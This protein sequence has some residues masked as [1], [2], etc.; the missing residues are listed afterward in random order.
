[1][2]GL[3]LV[4]GSAKRIGRAIALDLA[5]HGWDIVVHYNRS[6]EEAKTLAE[7]IQAL[8]QMAYLAEIDLSNTD[9][10]EKLIPFLTENLGPLDA[11][12]NNAALFE[13]DAT[14]PDGTRHWAVNAD[15]PRLLSKSLR[16]SLNKGDKSVVVN[17]LD[18]T[19]TAPT[20]LAY[21]KSKD[22][23]KTLTVNMA[24]SFAPQVRVNGVAPMYVLPSPRQTEDSFREM[25]GSRIATVEDVAKTVRQLIESPAITG[26]IVSVG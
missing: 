25:A 16:D 22:F 3:A 20:F 18:A 9:L 5:A 15:A 10:A 1:M 21:G 23:L 8:G 2:K 6:A 24:K 26:E 13:P 17:L 12:I 4:T 14:D 11:L 7:E 19:P